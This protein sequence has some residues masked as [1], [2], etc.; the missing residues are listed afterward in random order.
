MNK[1]P[2]ACA[3]TRVGERPVSLLV[4]RT[5]T[6]RG[7]TVD[8]CFFSHR[9]IGIPH[10]PIWGLR[11]AAAGLSFTT[12]ARRGCMARKQR[13]R[14]HRFRQPRLRLSFKNRRAGDAVGVTRNSRRHLPSV[15]IFYIFPRGHL[16]ARSSR[17]RCATKFVLH[18]LPPDNTSFRRDPTR[19]TARHAEMISART[20]L[21][22]H[23]EQAGMTLRAPLRT[24]SPDKETWARSATRALAP[25]LIIAMITFDRFD[26][27]TLA[28][29]PD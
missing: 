21:S 13:S 29:F 25:C 9:Q 1:S 18:V 24:T 11:G 5:K 19:L 26:V 28:G 8:G 3:R 15:Y 7:P 23:D 6:E 14:N 12:A 27:S 2:H 4:C 17:P 10:I 20:T 16:S 22:L